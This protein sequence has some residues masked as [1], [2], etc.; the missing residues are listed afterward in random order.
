MKISRYTRTKNDWVK[1]RRLKGYMGKNGKWIYDSR[2]PLKYQQL[3][4]APF[5][6]SEKCCDKTKK[7]PLKEYE[8]KTRKHPITGEMAE[9]SKDRQDEYLKH[10]CIMHDKQ[11]PKC[12]P[13][14]FWTTQDI[15]QCIYEN[16]IK[17]VLS[18]ASDRYLVGDIQKGL[19]RANQPSKRLHYGKNSYAAQTF[20]DIPSEDGRRIKIGWNTMEVPNTYFNNS[21]CFPTEMKL[22]TID[23][24]VYLCVNPIT[25][26]QKLYVN[27]NTNSGIN[28][29]EEDPFSTLLTGK[30]QDIEIQIEADEN[31]EFSIEFLG[32]EIIC[33]VKENL[34]QIHETTMPLYTNN[35]EVR[36]RLLVD[37]LGLE[38]FSDQGQ[39]H[40]CI[41]FL[42]DYNIKNLEIKAVNNSVI[43][44]KCTVSELKNIWS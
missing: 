36:L 43:L 10:G 41:G 21:M 9:E 7:K 28:I 25:E 22:K 42:C 6:F 35:G 34:L 33:K 3:I 31:S 11:R 38:V 1:E 27:T 2:I 8:H 17:W 19:F 37:T 20:S 12:T 40:M 44:K 13:I 24:E 4:Y 39:A 18:G 30:T 14:G 26:I 15:M 29:T 23:S 32:M 5:E 16:N